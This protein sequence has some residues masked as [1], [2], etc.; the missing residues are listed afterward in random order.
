MGTLHEN[1]D[2]GQDRG[3]L[4]AAVHELRDF[5]AQ[6]VPATGKDAPACVIACCPVC[7]GEPDALGALRVVVVD[8]PPRL[9]WHCS[10]HRGGFRGVEYALGKHVAKKPNGGSDVVLST[11]ELDSTKTDRD[12][13]PGHQAA[14]R[15]TAGRWKV[16]HC[17]SLGL[18][19]AMSLR[20]RKCLPCKNFR[21]EHRRSRVL[22]RLMGCSS[23]QPDD[24]KTGRA[25]RG[26]GRCSAGCSPVRM[27]EMDSGRY[28]SATRLLRAHKQ[29]F[30]GVPTAEGRVLLTRS[31]LL[32]GDEIASENLESV[33]AELINGMP[34]G[35][36][37]SV[38]SGDKRM[39][40]A[41]NSTTDWVDI[42]STKKNTAEQSVIYASYGCR[43]VAVRT[44]GASSGSVVMWSV[45]HLTPDD[46]L[47]LHLSLGLRVWGRG[48]ESSTDRGAALDVA[49]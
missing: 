18:E 45:A 29:P 41:K 47:K 8:T 6:F 27:V 43:E 15:C 25:L 35:S 17:Q 28:Q 37:I 32:S 39:L 5:G 13:V 42:G 4:A 40:P 7:K 26:R 44:P 12:P 9:D 38:S 10:L 22:G 36:K 23:C 16:Q 49:A 46:L 21:K 2:H 20:C 1:G 19:R 3:I 48:N 30:A 33:V 14:L 31:N 34:P 24:A 11:K